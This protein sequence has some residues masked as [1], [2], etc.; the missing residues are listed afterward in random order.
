MTKQ[1][2]FRKTLYSI[3]AALLGLLALFGVITADQADTWGKTLTDVLDVVVPLIG[4]G[5]LALAA[6]KVHRGSDS[7][8]TEGDV[9]RA[10]SHTEAQM[11]ASGEAPEPQPEDLDVAGLAAADYRRM[12]RDNS[13]GAIG[14]V[15]CR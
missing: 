12:T 1:Q 7:Q 11:I 10:V 8:A 9:R 15:A 13:D 5:S 4:T 14:G 3:V 6:T 2:I